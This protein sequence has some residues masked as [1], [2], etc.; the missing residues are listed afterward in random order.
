LTNPMKKFP[1]PILFILL[2]S[3]AWATTFFLAPASGGGNDSNN[4][5]SAS[6]P[7]LSPNH[8]VKCGDAIIAAPSTAYSAS[9]FA[10]GKWG[11]VTCP[12]GN[13]VAW[14]ICSSFDAC[15]ISSSSTDGMHISA[16]FWGV[17]GWEVTTTSGAGACFVANPPNGSTIH[18]I[19][20]AND[21]ANGCQANGFTSFNSGSA[22]VDY[23]I[24]VGNIAY[25]AA[26]AGSECYSGISI[27]QPQNSDTAAGTH[28]FVAG[29]FSFRNLDPSSCAGGQPTDG[30][31]IIL[32]TFDGSQGSLPS[33]YT[34]QAVAENNVLLS[35]G[36]RG[37]ELYNNRSGPSPAPIYAL[38]NTLWGNN[39]DK[40][41]NGTY[42]GEILISFASNVQVA[43]DLAVTNAANG[44][45]NNP[46]YAYYV[47]SVNTT[48]S[49]HNTAGYS[50]SGTNGGTNNSSGFSY[51]PNNLFGTNPNFAN[52][53][54][55]G[56]PS[57]GGASSVPNCMASVIANFTPQAALAAGYGYQVPSTTQTSDPLFPQWLCNVN[58][59]PGL[60][61]M[62]CLS[63]S[64]TLTPPTITSVTVK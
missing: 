48:V 27:Y 21:V 49:I 14:L 56:A 25:N 6:T 26:Q 60:V 24:L 5:A 62:G 37:F 59:P 34:G 41:Q 39:T 32:D 40:N 61:T 19:I 64:S 57:C 13:N 31:G 11:A 46:I 29:N 36:G 42:C 18:H 55:P 63:A 28:I 47:G 4:G 33:P 22:S 12:N 58:L 54:E 2:A 7:W 16:N 3:P 43:S 30:E 44:C 17:Q 23:F 38:H 8:L 51:G 50:A 53:V 35:N 9:D 45:G 1:L 52:P 15:K 10:S 20:F